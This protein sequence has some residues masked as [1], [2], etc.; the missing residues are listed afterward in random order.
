MSAKE[1]IASRKHMEKV[2]SLSGLPQLDFLMELERQLETGKKTAKKSTVSLPPINTS[3]EYRDSLGSFSETPPS[4]NNSTSPNTPDCVELGAKAKN[5]N[6]FLPSNA[7][8]K[9][10]K[11]IHANDSLK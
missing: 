9:S 10:G 1:K 2:P 6:I 7:T 8:Y 3:T 11:L 4:S 5:H